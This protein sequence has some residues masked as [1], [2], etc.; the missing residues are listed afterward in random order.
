MF[1]L[2]SIA[3]L[4]LPQFMLDVAKYPF[5]GALLQA[6]FDPEV[7]SLLREGDLYSAVAEYVDYSDYAHDGAMY[8]YDTHALIA[9]LTELWF[10]VVSS[11]PLKTAFLQHS[12]SDSVLQYIQDILRVFDSLQ[13]RATTWT[14]TLTEIIGARLDALCIPGVCTSTEKYIVAEPLQD[15]LEYFLRML[16][17]FTRILHDVNQRCALFYGYRHGKM[18]ARGLTDFSESMYSDDTL[19]ITEQRT[20]N[21]AQDLWGAYAVDVLSLQTQ[22]YTTLDMLCFMRESKEYY[23]DS[24][25]KQYCTVEESRLVVILRQ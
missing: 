22:H 24:R 2:E 10:D 17:R 11:V 12:T 16:A 8:V 14:H 18:T 6:P 20:N 23:T 5:K 13:T 1:P 9:R 25:V 3:Y 19:E 4:Y 21:L 15:T 7:K